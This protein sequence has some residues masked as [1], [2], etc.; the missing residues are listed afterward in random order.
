VDVRDLLRALGERRLT[1][2]LVEGGGAVLGS[3]F[4]ADAVDQVMVFIAP[5][6]IGGSAAPG[7]LG[8][9]GVRRVLDALPV[10]NAAVQRIGTDVMVEAYLRKAVDY[11]SRV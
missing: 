9:V 8:G 4:D 7:P 11:L 10:S 5:K 2:L 1:N 6:I 3:F